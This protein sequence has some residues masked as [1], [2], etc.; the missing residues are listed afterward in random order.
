MH[1][2]FG[3]NVNSFKAGPEGRIPKPNLLLEGF[4]KSQQSFDYLVS[5]REQSTE[6][7]CKE[8]HEAQ[9]SLLPESVQKQINV[10]LSNFSRSTNDI[11]ISHEG[12]I[13]PYE[14]SLT[15]RVDGSSTT[16]PAEESTTDSSIEEDSP[17]PAESTPYNLGTHFIWIGERTSNLEEA[18]VEFFRG[19]ANPIGLKVGPRRT[20]EEIV[21]SCRILNPNNAMG[22][23]VLILR[24]GEKLSD[25]LP[26][27]LDHIKSEGIN[28]V[29]V[30]DPMHANT[31]QTENKIKTRSVQRIM[32][33]I[34]ETQKI[35]S[36]KAMVL[37]GLHLE[38]VG[39]NVTECINGVDALT[40][41]HLTQNYTTQC[42]PRLNYS[43][44]IQVA[45]HFAEC[46]N[47]E[48]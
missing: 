47:S 16:L 25:S 19:I 9:V 46:F 12:L 15:R 21:K 2:Y 34:A 35:F 4:K 48:A 23:L 33:E 26:S 32:D 27:V 14:E 30:I 38:L 20:P 31:F 3:D 24:M 28:A 37:G 18:H 13:L 8:H 1:S 22:K 42:D 29:F 41:E 11:Y 36:E 43:Q 45:T 17:S 5:T 40:S 44:S 7:L 10:D 6:N 39:L